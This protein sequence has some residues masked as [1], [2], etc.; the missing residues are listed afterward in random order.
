MFFSFVLLLACD[1]YPYFHEVLLPL[2]HVCHRVVT[3]LLFLVILVLLL[4]ICS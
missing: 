3:P 4:A 1:F 2:L